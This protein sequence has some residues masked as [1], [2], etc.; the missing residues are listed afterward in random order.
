MLSS[1]FVDEPAMSYRVDV[2]IASDGA[3]VHWR[4]WSPG[5]IPGCQILLI[6][7]LAA[8]SNSD[9]DPQF[10]RRSISHKGWIEVRQMLFV[11]DS[12]RVNYA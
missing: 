5:H 10:P 11:R 2:V 8:T 1:K 9:P 12:P 3:L 4:S 7:Q 6:G